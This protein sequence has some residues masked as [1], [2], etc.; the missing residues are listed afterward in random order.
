MISGIP[1][2]FETITKLYGCELERLNC[3]VLIFFV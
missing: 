1:G 2:L 3:E